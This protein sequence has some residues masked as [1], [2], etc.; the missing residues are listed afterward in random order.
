MFERFKKAKNKI[1]MDYTVWIKS[2][3][4]HVSLDSL[5]MVIRRHEL[6]VIDITYRQCSYHPSNYPGITLHLRGTEENCLKFHKIAVDNKM[7]EFG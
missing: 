4:D 3:R 5:F 6:E 2:D 7:Y 1:E